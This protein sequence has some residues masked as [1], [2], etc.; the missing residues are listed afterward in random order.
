MSHQREAGPPFFAVDEGEPRLLLVGQFGPGHVGR[1]FHDAATCLELAVACV[2]VTRAFEGPT[3]A[4]RVSWHLYGHRPTRLRSFGRIVVDLCR[5]VRPTWMLATGFAP[6]DVA[7]LETIGALGVTRLNFLTDD[8]WNPAHHAP[9]F[10][11]ALPHYDEVFSPRGANI[12]DL[13]KHG[14]AAVSYL[15]FAYNPGLHFP[16]QPS[17]ED[18]QHLGCDVLFVGGADAERVRWLGRLSREFRVGLYGGY[19][20]RYRETRSLSRGL[21]PP[22]FV[23]Q[24][25]GASKVSVALVRRANR[26]S[27]AMRSYELPAMAACIVAEE[28]SDHRALFGDEGDAV[29]YFSSPTELIEKI[30]WLLDNHELRGPM[31]VNAN[32]AIVSKPNTYRDRLVSMLA[33]DIEQEACPQV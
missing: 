1:H 29:L 13:R 17:V 24:A 16:Q 11:E 18:H 7:T 23:R 12:E 33:L 19:W 32:K 3:W 6:L 10:L 8:P 14:C 22:E 31:A 30:R 27:H 9:W 28:T 20:E 2:D 21:L 4:R 5:T 25:V 15:P 26:D